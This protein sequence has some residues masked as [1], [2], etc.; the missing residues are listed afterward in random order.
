[1]ELEYRRASRT[2]TLRAEGDVEGEGNR[3]VGYAALF[4][5]ES[6][7]LYD[8][9]LGEFVEVID[10]KAFDRTLKESPDVRALYNH[11]T[12]LVLGRTKSGT[13]TLTV[14]DVGLYFEVELPDTQAARDLRE[15]VRR[16]D[17]DGCSFGFFVEADEVE[18]REDGPP[19]R[20]LLDVTLF[21]ITTG[22]AFPAYEDTSV[23]L[24]TV[25]KFE[26]RKRSRIRTRNARLR[27]AVEDMD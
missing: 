20:R 4:D 21:E 1:M 12:N 18:E 24:R 9:K 26:A 11:D 7:Q 13:L 23:S 6:Q 10:P 25:E 14:D 17:I 22:C 8:P 27:L 5:V 2:I 16:G 3:L 15:S 19:L